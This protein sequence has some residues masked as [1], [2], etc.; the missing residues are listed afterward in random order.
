MPGKYRSS[1]STPFGAASGNWTIQSNP[2]NNG[3]VQFGTMVGASRWVDDVASSGLDV[4][5]FSSGKNGGGMRVV[6]TFHNRGS[7]FG[8]D[9]RLLFAPAAGASY[10]TTGACAI[11]VTL[12]SPT[13]YRM[14]LRPG[15]GSAAPTTVLTVDGTTLATTLSGGIV[16]PISASK[17]GAYT[18][19]T[20]DYMVRCDA[21]SGAFDVTLPNANTC[22]G[23]VF[24]VKRTSAANTVTVKSGGGTLDGVAAGT[25]IPLDAQFKTRAFQSDGTNWH[26]VGAYL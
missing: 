12:S 22:A 9:V 13:I 14:A 20:A 7:S 16:L 5:N 3:Y 10:P 18:V 24:V 2:S 17:T 11:D 15:N 4:W 25:G 26:I 21:T 6:A 8:D 1:F 19:T 23:Q